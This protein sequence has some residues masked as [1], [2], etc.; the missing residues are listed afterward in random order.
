[1]RESER[2][3]I[4]ERTN[5]SNFNRVLVKKSINK[6]AKELDDI[7]LMSKIEHSFVYNMCHWF[8]DVKFFTISCILKEC[9]QDAINMNRFVNLSLIS[10]YFGNY[11]VLILDLLNFIVKFYRDYCVDISRLRLLAY[12]LSDDSNRWMFNKL[13]DWSHRVGR[14]FILHLSNDRLYVQDFE[15]IIEID[16]KSPGIIER[17][18]R[19]N[20]HSIVKKPLLGIKQCRTWDIIDTIWLNKKNSYLKNFPKEIM[21][22]M[23]SYFKFECDSNCYRCYNDV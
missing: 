4:T 6:I 1:M 2:Y 3:W 19:R 23:I 5:F 12:C 16:N 7:D 22:Y 14:N 18:C 20:I 11:N 10:G 8:G 15:Q 17:K 21:D 13:I 9:F